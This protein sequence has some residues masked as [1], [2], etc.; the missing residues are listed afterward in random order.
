MSTDSPPAAPSESEIVS[1]TSSPSTASTEIVAPLSVWAGSAPL[2][3]A[4]T[5]RGPEAATV[6]SNVDGSEAAAPVAF[7]SANRNVSSP[8]VWPSSVTETV[9]SAVGV[10]SPAANVRV[11]VV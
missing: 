9:T 10:V 7:W 4:N 1:V 2:V 5:A 3:A 11:W 6:R 8:S